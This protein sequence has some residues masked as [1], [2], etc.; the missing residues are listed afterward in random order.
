MSPDSGYMWLVVELAETP[1]QR[2]QASF[3]YLDAVSADGRMTKQ[4]RSMSP[5]VV[6]VVVLH[7]L[8]NGWRP[9]RRGLTPFRVNG[10]AVLARG[11]DAPRG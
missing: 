9:E 11:A 6:R 4:G 1:G 7:A 3:G 2:I 8:A 10:D 5:S